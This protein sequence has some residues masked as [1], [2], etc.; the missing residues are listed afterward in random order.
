M[1]PISFEKEKQEGTYQLEEHDFAYW[2]LKSR[3][4]EKTILMTQANHRVGP[5]IKAASY[6]I[7]SKNVVLKTEEEFWSFTEAVDSFLKIKEF[8]SIE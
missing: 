8:F 3:D 6:K 1:E 4:G 5:A 2:S 7:Y